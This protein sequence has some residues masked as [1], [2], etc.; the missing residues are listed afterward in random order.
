MPRHPSTTTADPVA[1]G[2]GVIYWNPVKGTT[3]DTPF[4]KLLVAEGV[5]VVDHEPQSAHAAEDRRTVTR[6]RTAT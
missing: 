2:A 6:R 4:G 3:V 5:P 1:R